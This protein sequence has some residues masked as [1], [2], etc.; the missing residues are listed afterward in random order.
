MQNE[1]DL[2]IL[3]YNRITFTTGDTSAAEDKKI[4]G[5]N[6]GDNDTGIE[7][8]STKSDSTNAD[9]LVEETMQLSKS[10]SRYI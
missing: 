4:D 2:W 5:K 8:K 1:I 10:P 9:S 6:D 3:L 7:D